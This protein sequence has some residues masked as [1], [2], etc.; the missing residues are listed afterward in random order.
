MRSNL[1]QTD[2]II[3]LSLSIGFALIGLLLSYW[4]LLILAGALLISALFNYSLV[5][6]IF[7]YSTKKYHASPFHSKK[8]KHHHSK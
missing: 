8:K 4:W 7:G 2:K 1:S 6:A 5:Y 3:R